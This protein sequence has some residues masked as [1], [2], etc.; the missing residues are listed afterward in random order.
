MKDKSSTEWT[1]FNGYQYKVI[2]NFTVQFNFSFAQNICISLDSNLV[3]IHSTEENNFV[4]DLIEKFPTN[5]TELTK[6]A[7]I[8]LQQDCNVWKWID[9][10]PM[11]F[12]NWKINEPD[13]SGRKECGI[14]CRD[15]SSL[16]NGWESWYC[17][18]ISQ[19][20]TITVCKKPV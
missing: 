17:S 4:S 20:I 11:D 10:S 6:F 16:C 14:I 19:T 15:K 13:I 3:S 2:A 5:Y 18:K 9:G 1:S 7:W 12:Q 8:G